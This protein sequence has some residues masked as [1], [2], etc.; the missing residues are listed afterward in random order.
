PGDLLPDYLH[1]YLDS[2]VPPRPPELAAMEAY[3]KEVDFPIIGP[4]SGQLCYQVARMI[5]ARRIFELGSG[6][7]Y[8]TAW[9]ARA[10]QEN[11]GGEVHH[12][13]WD[14]ALSERA[15]GHLGALGYD[16]IVRYHVAEAVA[17]LQA[18]EGPFDLIFNDI[19]KQAYPDSLP[20]I[21]EK[22][23]PGGV[24]II[25][26]MLWSGA[27]FDESDQSA[28]TVGVREFTRLI[29]NDSA[30]V[31]SLVPVRDGVIVAY[32]SDQMNR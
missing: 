31:V 16:S 20:V 1:G 32:K 2:L 5:G 24:L 7:G 10:V 28:S 17:T 23:R 25:D 22:L 14:E 27:I 30:W 26:N 9:F 11:G 13:V 8:S 29:T 18:T 4:A 19:D 15:R 3:A 21:A 6:Y 12:V